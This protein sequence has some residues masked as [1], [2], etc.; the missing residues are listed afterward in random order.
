MRY[1]D[2][3]KQEERLEPEIPEDDL[4]FVSDAN[5]AILANTPKG[6]RKILIGAAAFFGIM[7][8]WA[9]VAEIDEVT[10]GEGKVIPSSQVQIIQ[11]LE[12]GIL[13]EIMIKEGQTV[14]K[15]QVLL[16]IDD[17]RFGAK[18]RGSKMQRYALEA[19][20]ARLRAEAEGRKS[21][22]IPTEVIKSAPKLG[23]Q[24]QDLFRSR[25]NQ[26]KATIDILNQQVAQ[27]KQEV[28][29]LKAKEK[30]LSRS[31]AL[32]QKQLNISKPLVR[33]G[34]VSEVEILKLEREVA[35]LQG[36]LDATRLSI[37]RVRSTL[38][39]ARQ[40]VHERELQFQNEARTEYNEV[41]AELAPLKESEAAQEDT[42]R[43]TSVRSPVRGTVKQLLINTV[44]GVIQPGADLVEIVPLED[45]LLI[46]A[47]IRPQDIAFLR[48]GQEATIKFTAYDFA[49]FGGLTA[50]VEHISADTIA[51]EKGNSFYLVRLRTEQNYLGTDI[52]PLPIIP[53]MVA[54]VDVLT[55]KKTILNYL[56]KPV[57]RA[58]HRALSER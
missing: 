14:Q 31:H 55:G 36:D 22:A 12:G 40:K 49:I 56:L 50:K 10:K 25:Q 58:K 13:Q 41:I 39:E 34:A 20:S 17:T 26:L 44:G 46:E 27:K 52:K 30:Q 21:F 57:L 6:G 43:R 2:R 9:S 1:F 53:G 15:N 16:R 32:A 29:E 51:D 45:T 8:F 11:N 42:F 28:S 5:A 54:E 18:L 47:K 37:P 24:E 19:K 23:R 48:P 3:G 35:Q 7:L 4:D 33:Q 38:K